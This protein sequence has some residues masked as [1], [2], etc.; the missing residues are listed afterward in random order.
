MNI[1]VP[2]KGRYGTGLAKTVICLIDQGLPF[3]LVVE[4]Q[5]VQWYSIAYPSAQIM[6]LRDSNQGIAYVR[7]QI[8]STAR[9]EMKRHIWML[10]DDIS[11]LSV[12]VNGRNVKASHW[13]VIFKA[14][15]Q[16]FSE[17]DAAQGALEYQQFSWSAKKDA[18]LNSYCDVAVWIDVDRTRH[19]SYRKEVVLKEDRDFTLQVLNSGY[20]TCRASKL[21]FAV[22][23]NGS[24]AGGLQEEYARS[25]KEEAAVD[26]MCRFWPGIVTR[27]VKKDGR[28]D[29]KINWKMVATKSGL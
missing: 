24:N 20:R 27:Q 11:S 29:C 4:P 23:K 1:F 17:N 12:Q 7:N 15:Q 8:L 26:R 19:L 22:P 13:E 6:P 2:S 28:I 9:Q 10:D 18:S 21:G 3:T 25:G 16:L 14:A 5:E